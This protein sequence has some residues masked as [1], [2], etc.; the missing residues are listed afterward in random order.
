MSRD[1]SKKPELVIVSDTPIWNGP[2][3]LVAFEP[4]VREIEHFHNLFGKI[5]WIGYSHDSR[6]V[7]KMA[8]CF[9]NGVEVD[10]ILLPLVGG[11]S[12]FDKI[13]ILFKIPSYFFTVLKNLKKGDVVHTRA[14]SLPAFFAILNS[15]LDKKRI[16]WHK[17]AGN[18][19]AEDIPYFY[20]LQRSL[21]KK[22]TSTRVTMNGAWPNQ[23]KHCLSFENPCLSDEELHNANSLAKQKTYEKELVICFVGALK[24]FKGIL[25]FLEALNNLDNKYFK[26]VLI[27]GDGEVR[28]QV[29]KLAQKSPMD[30]KILGY[31]NRVQLEKIYTESHFCI[32]PS[33]SEGFPKVI[34]EAVSFGCIPIVTDISCLSQYI[35][36]GQNGFLLKDNRPNTIK[37]KLESIF[38]QGH[39]LSK[40]GQEALTLSHLFTYSRYNQRIKD[41]ILINN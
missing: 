7:S 13:K 19:E 30:I 17:Y 23:P 12:I 6:K 37:D 40:M 34:A 8:R 5:T 28:Q 18:W 22:A 29:E 3:G 2:D 36:D 16:Y 21:L 39:D 35:I 14:P 26:K 1:I 24:A 25:S 10:F 32:L 31:Q 9:Q 20:S 15:F 41:E 11:R 38:S 33:A 27:A 4:V